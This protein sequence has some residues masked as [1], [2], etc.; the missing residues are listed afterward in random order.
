MFGRKYR[1][2]EAR[3]DRFETRIAKIE[4]PDDKLVLRV[5]AM[6]AQV[7]RLEEC[8]KDLKEAVQM[9]L[10]GTEMSLKALRTG[11]H[12][13]AVDMTAAELR[14]KGIE[15]RFS[16]HERAIGDLVKREEEE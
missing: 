11:A 14:L 7:K 13:L 4:K 2:L 15:E 8:L 9:G 6:E 5:G 3:L 10:T 12:E 16:M 1:V